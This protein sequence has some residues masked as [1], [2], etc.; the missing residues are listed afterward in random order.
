L[1]VAPSV[2][3]AGDLVDVCGEWAIERALII[4]IDP[5]NPDRYL[6]RIQDK[7]HT[8]H[9]MRAS[10]LAFVGRSSGYRTGPIVHHVPK[11]TR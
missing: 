9:W 2:F 6:V 8:E 3:S 7:G 11:E 10:R 4:R 5:T 1:I